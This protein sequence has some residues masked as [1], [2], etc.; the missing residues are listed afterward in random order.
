MNFIAGRRR[1]AYAAWGMV[2][3]AGLTVT[4]PMAEAW[5][6]DEFVFPEHTIDVEYSASIPSTGTISIASNTFMSL[7][8]VIPQAL[9]HSVT[10]GFARFA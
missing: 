9:G 10:T 7:V 6:H 4:M 1:G 3:A 8:D 5:R 2:V